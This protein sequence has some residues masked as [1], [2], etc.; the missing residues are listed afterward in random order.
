M[1]LKNTAGEFIQL[2]NVAGKSIQFSTDPNGDAPEIT[3]PTAPVAVRQFLAD[4]NWE[5]KVPAS[6]AQF[7]ADATE[8]LISAVEAEV[9]E[10][11]RQAVALLKE[12]AA[13]ATH[14]AELS[15]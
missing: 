13:T 4:H 11:D 12:E 3:Y 2:K 6:R 8:P 10:A 14:A 15:A 7:A 1:Q 9:S 5:A